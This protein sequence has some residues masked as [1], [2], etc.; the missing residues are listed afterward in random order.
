MPHSTIL[1]I[2]FGFTVPLGR[3][4]HIHS[5]LIGLH[6]RGLSLHRWR[7]QCLG[8]CMWKLS[9]PLRLN[10]RTIKNPIFCTSM[11]LVQKNI[12]VINCQY[13]I[14]RIISSPSHRLFSPIFICWQ[15]LGLAE[16][17]HALDWYRCDE[18]N[19]KILLIMINYTQKGSRIRVRFYDI[20]LPTFTKVRM[21][22]QYSFIIFNQFCSQCKLTL[23]MTLHFQVI[24]SICS[25]IVVL[26][27]CFSSRNR[28]GLK[29]KTGR[30]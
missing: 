4:I 19:E 7:R 9:F 6:S 17:I 27:R 3:G 24:G 20:E 1:I 26:E 30:T 14:C 12:A 18:I 16:S 21:A 5:V 29:D 22:C 15:S 23:T 8:K 10:L 2:S 11:K 25:Y 28:Y 13:R